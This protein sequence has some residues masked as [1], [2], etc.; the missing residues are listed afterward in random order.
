MTLTGT[1]SACPLCRAQAAA[2]IYNSDFSFHCF[3]VVLPV[4]ALMVIGLGLYH[5]DDPMGKVEK[6]EAE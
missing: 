1:L 2:G 6:E 4:F 3:I 5:A